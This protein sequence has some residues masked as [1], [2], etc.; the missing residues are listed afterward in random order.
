M[1]CFF[2]I[3]ALLLLP[4]SSSLIIESQTELALAD[5]QHGMLPYPGSPASSLRGRIG[6][7][8]V[9]QL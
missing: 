9:L 4:S 1:G 2:S 6:S 8:R 3:Q 7:F 5:L